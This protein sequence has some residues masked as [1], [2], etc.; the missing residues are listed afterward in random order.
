MISF[1]EQLA[2][3]VNAQANHGGEKA[4]PPGDKTPGASSLDDHRVRGGATRGERA[5][6]RYKEIFS[7]EGNTVAKASA[8]MGLSHV[9]C[10]NQCYRYERRGLLHRKNERDKDTGALI[11]V[12]GPKPENQQ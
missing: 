7:G 1:V 10:L 4:K 6:N 11:F 3:A 9:G 12:W 5:Q 2:R 8:I